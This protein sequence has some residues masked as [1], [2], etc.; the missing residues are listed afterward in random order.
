MNKNK[1][2]SGILSLIIIISLVLIFITSS[3]NSIETGFCQPRISCHEDTLIFQTVSC[4]LLVNTNSEELEICSK[5]KLSE[6][7]PLVQ[8]SIGDEGTTLIID[9]QLLDLEE[10]ELKW[11]YYPQK[12]IPKKYSLTSNVLF[13]PSEEITCFK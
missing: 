9:T 3:S 7:H 6:D 1:K 10:K 11:Q 12:N 4:G 2:F 8:T 13:S 5:G